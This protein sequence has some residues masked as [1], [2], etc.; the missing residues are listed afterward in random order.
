[1]HSE[2]D[3]RPQTVMD[4][5]RGRVTVKNESMGIVLKVTHTDDGSR[6]E[7]DE[8]ERGIVRGV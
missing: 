7:R 6:E 8:Q 4:A 1:M 5:H 3:E 2:T